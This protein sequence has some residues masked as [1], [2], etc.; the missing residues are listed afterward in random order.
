MPAWRDEPSRGQAAP[1][2]VRRLA[3]L[4]DV[5]DA[6]AALLRQHS[7]RLPVVLVESRDDGPAA[8]Y[9]HA[10]TRLLAELQRLLGRP[11]AA[12]CRVQVV[13]R[14]GTPQGWA[15]LLGML[16]TAAQED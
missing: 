5:P 2:G 9:E 11:A 4:C 16:R 13:C 7:P 1:A 12:P 14:E 15:G 3:V 6:E 8:A 10:A